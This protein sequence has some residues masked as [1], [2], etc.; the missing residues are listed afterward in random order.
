MQ[1]VG[2]PVGCDIAAVAPDGTHFHAAHRLPDVLA[3]LNLTET[4]DLCA[5]RRHDALRNRSRF[6][7]DDG[8]R[9]EGP[10]TMRR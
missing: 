6:A 10:Q 8:L 7:A 3:V 5:R 4:D 9:K 2:G 1:V